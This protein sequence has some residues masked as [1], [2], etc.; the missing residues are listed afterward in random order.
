MFLVELRRPKRWLS[1][2]VRQKTP[3]LIEQT[4]RLEFLPAYQYQ[5]VLLEERLV[6]SNS[7]DSSTV[8]FA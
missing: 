1:I 5:L 8:D 3:Y 6:Q 7:L 4:K 2:L